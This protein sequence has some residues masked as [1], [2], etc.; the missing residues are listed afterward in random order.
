MTATH[1]WRQW[2][3]W[4]LRLKLLAPVATP[5]QSDTLFGHL[6]WQVVLTKGSDALKEW[7]QP[8]TDGD[9]PFIL[10]DAFPAGLLPKPLFSVSFHGDSEISGL[11]PAK[12]Y[13]QL[14][15]IKKASFLSVED[16]RRT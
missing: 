6:C 13:D 5:M 1:D 3:D 2:T 9:P 14:K 7:L 8:F 12:K 11:N 4:R 15:K 16:F 10:S